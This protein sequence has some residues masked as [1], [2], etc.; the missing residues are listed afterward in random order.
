[1]YL[2]M[3]VRLR[4]SIRIYIDTECVYAHTHVYAEKVP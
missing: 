2:C 3:R 1:M 4:S